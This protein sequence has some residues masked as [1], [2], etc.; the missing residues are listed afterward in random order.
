MNKTNSNN[1][2]TLSNIIKCIPMS[3]YNY[4]SKSNVRN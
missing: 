4:G 2:H 1:R 3:W